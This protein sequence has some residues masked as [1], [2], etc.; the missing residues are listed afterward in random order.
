M[1]ITFGI[2]LI[3]FLVLKAYFKYVLNRYRSVNRKHP[4]LKEFYTE[5]M[6]K[7]LNINDTK[8]QELRNVLSQSKK[9]I[10]FN[11]LGAGSRKG[12]KSDKRLVSEILKNSSIQ[13][14]HGKLLSRMVEYYGIRNSAE[15]GTSLGLGTA[16][17]ALGAQ[18][19]QIQ[20]IEGCESVY[21]LASHN[22][23]DL[24]IEQQIKAYRANFDDVLEDLF[25]LNTS[26]D[27]VYIDGNHTYEAT[28]RYFEFFLKRLNKNG[29]IIF[30]DIYW[31]DGMEKAWNEIKESDQ[32]GVSID[33]FRMGI[34]SKRQFETRINGAF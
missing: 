30:D 8:I 21:E 10:S 12:T 24:E 1:L 2:K 13:Q 28:K 32:I 5:V 26:L 6:K 29:F 33:L 14:K 15:L 16:Y 7:S 25:P 23:K 4:F 22:F 34:V 3:P 17:L 18:E 19:N 11:D 31:S 27:L 9:Q 20:T